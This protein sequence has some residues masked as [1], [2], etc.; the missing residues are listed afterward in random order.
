MPVRKIPKNHLVVT[1][2]FASA[3]ADRMIGFESLLEKEYMLLLDFDETVAGYEEQPIRVPVP[4]VPRGYVVDLLVRFRH[5][6]MRPQLVEVK[7][8]EFLDRYVNEYAPKFAAAE[9]FCAEREWTFIK[10]TEVD[11]RT[12][13]L[14]NLKFLRA[15]RNVFP[16]SDQ[17]QAV[18]SAMEDLNGQSSSEGLLAALGQTAREAWLPVIW[19]MLLCGGLSTC[20]DAV[21]PVDVPLSLPGRVS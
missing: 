3:K 5:P 7:P 13:R 19:H 11:I 2:G 21:L 18:L 6:D 12:P 14:A 1:G 15:Y 8:Q 9:A 4:G 17:K 16:T 20:M 10:K